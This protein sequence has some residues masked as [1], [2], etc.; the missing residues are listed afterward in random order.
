MAIFNGYV[1]TVEVAVESS[2]N[3]AV[4]GCSCSLDNLAMGYMVIDA[5]FTCSRF[6]ATLYCSQCLLITGDSCTI[7]SYLVFLA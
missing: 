5:I 2:E 1:K 7:N 3:A 6:I 4:P